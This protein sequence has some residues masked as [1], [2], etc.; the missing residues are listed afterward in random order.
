MGLDAFIDTAQGIASIFLTSVLR[1]YDLT[2]LRHSSNTQAWAVP[3]TIPCGLSTGD[4][5]GPDIPM[6]QLSGFGIVAVLCCGCR[7]G[8]SSTLIPNA[9]TKHFLANDRKSYRTRQ[10]PSYTPL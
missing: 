1:H 7:Y 10:E 9:I 5:R 3:Y 2:G 8:G 6:Q 4:S